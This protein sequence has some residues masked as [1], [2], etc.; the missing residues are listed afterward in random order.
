MEESNWIYS[1]IASGTLPLFA[2]SGLLINKDDVTR[3]LELHH[4]QKLDVSIFY[5][6]K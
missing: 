1:Q 5:F 3:F 4:I 6:Y 2:E